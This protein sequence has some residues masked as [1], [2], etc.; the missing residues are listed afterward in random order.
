AK[1][2][3]PVAAL[4]MLAAGLIA[5]GFVLWR[6]KPVPEPAELK[7]WPVVVAGSLA[8]AAIAVIALMGR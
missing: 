6:A 2:P 8:A 5:A 7:P 4:T 3:P 1:V